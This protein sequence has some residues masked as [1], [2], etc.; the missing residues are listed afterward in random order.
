MLWITLPVPGPLTDAGPQH[1]DVRSRGV[2]AGREPQARTL[3]LRCCGEP[4]SLRGGVNRSLQ[5][6][7]VDEADDQDSFTAED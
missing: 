4:T 7:H 2:H 6:S 3:L 5:L 1:P